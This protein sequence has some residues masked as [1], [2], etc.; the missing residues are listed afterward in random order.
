MKKWHTRSYY[1]SKLN[2][3]KYLLPVNQ[4]DTEGY[5][6][7]TSCLNLT[8]WVFWRDIWRYKRDINYGWHIQVLFYLHPIGYNRET[9]T[10]FKISPHQSNII[11]EVHFTIYYIFQTHLGVPQ[12]VSLMPQVEYNAYQWTVE[13]RNI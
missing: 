2:Y 4:S 13:Y 7:N 12:L 3:R 6:N 9:L 11:N 8:R 5:L 1:R 10:S